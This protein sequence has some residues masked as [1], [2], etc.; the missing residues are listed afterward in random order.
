[1]SWSHVEV[2]QFTAPNIVGQQRAG[3]IERALGGVALIERKAPT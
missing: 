2:L 1:M 3:A